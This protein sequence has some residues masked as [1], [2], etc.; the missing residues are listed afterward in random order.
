[1]MNDDYKDFDE[2]PGPIFKGSTP[3]LEAMRLLYNNR[4]LDDFCGLSPAEMD[5]LLYEPYVE[6]SSLRIRTDISD[7][8]LDAIPF[9]RLAEELL[10]IIQ[11][12]KFVKLTPLGALPRK[13]LHE[14]YGHRFIPE[15][16]IEHGV[17]KLSREVDSIS[18]TSVH[19]TVELTGLTRKVHGKLMLTK[20]G[21]TFLQAGKRKELFSLIL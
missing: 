9:F 20:T 17:C 3:E 10:K 16:A 21:V 4:P 8:T 6:K 11:R 19:L 1:M 7:T 13:C 18:I 14:L 12:D 5:H 15:W 2:N